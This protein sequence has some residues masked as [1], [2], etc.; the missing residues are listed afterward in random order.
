MNQRGIGFNGIAEGETGVL[1][2][3]VLKLH[4]EPESLAQIL[5]KESPQV[6]GT[7]D[8]GGDGIVQ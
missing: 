3:P 8:V 6:L 4:L 1:P 7:Y 5:L 2:Q